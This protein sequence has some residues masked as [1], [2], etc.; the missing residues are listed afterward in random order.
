MN[1]TPLTSKEIQEICAMIR[2]ILI[3]VGDDWFLTGSG[4]RFLHMV[5]KGQI[6]NFVPRDC[7]FV[8][9]KKSG[10]HGFGVQITGSTFLPEI[11]L[12]KKEQLGLVTSCTYSLPGRSGLGTSFDMT[13]VTNEVPSTIVTLPDGFRPRIITIQKLREMYVEHDGSEFAIKCCDALLPPVKIN[14]IREEDKPASGIA[15]RLAF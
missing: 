1:F 12:F 13:Y 4:A 15:R 8:S 11:G 2:E 14:E 7:D 9:Y 5:A 6:P 3:L 10:K